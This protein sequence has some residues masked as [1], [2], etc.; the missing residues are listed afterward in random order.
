MPNPAQSPYHEITKIIRTNREAHEVV[1]GLEQVMKDLF[2]LNVSFEDSLKKNLPSPIQKAIT[3]FLAEKQP[4]P[5][6]KHELR[7]FF[8]DLIRTIRGLQSMQLTLAF[9]PSED[10]ITTISQWIKTNLN[11]ELLFDY[12]IDRR[13]VGGAVITYK[14]LFRDFSLHEILKEVIQQKRPE[15]ERLFA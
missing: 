9:S 12:T 15:I 5:T 4:Q 13:I 14:G 8:E 10:A 3:N 7:P 1:L 2:T 11:S 6:E